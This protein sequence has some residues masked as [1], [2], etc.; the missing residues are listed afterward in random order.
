MINFPY[1]DL[2]KK[3]GLVQI[4]P[5]QPPP[6]SQSPHVDHWTA[7][8]GSEEW[9]EIVREIQGTR[10]VRDA[11]LG[12]IYQSVEEA[13]GDPLFEELGQS[14]SLTDKQLTELTER[15]LVDLYRGILREMDPA[16]AIKTI[17]LRFPDKERP[18]Y[19]LFLTTHDPTG[20]LALNKILSEARIREYELRYIR[21]CAKRQLAPKG[22][23]SLFPLETV[24]MDMPKPETP[25][26]PTVE[27]CAEAILQRFS[28]STATR[29]DVY[30]ELAD[31]AYFDIEV[32]KAIRYL[33]K[34]KRAS[35][36]NRLSHNSIIKFFDN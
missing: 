15:R 19:H 33:R 2:Q 23:L 8:F 5:Y 3:T 17:R 18:M 26:R 20:A 12:G 13:E 24:Q 14:Y 36:S 11:L 25:D 28:G 1:Y 21:R 32:D 22:Q 4:P 7:A 10:E 30:R 6:Q 35:Y 29:R 16:L 34:T 9:I 31:E 27:E